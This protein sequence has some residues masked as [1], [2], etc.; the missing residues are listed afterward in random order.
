MKKKRIIISAVVCI[1]FALFAYFAGK[2]PFNVYP[3]EEAQFP[4]FTTTTRDKLLTAEHFQRM[5][6]LFVILLAA[7]AGIALIVLIRS[8]ISKDKRGHIGAAK[9]HKAFSRFMLIRW[10]SMIVLSFMMI[11]GGI[12][13]NARYE[14]IAIPVFACP[15]NFSEL[16][17]A[18]CFYLSHFPELLAHGIPATIIFLVSTLAFAIIFGRTICGF[19]CPMGLAQDILYKARQALK[20][21]GLAMNDRKYKYFVP[22]KWLMIILFFALVYAGGDFCEF[23]PAVVLSPVAAGIAWSLYFS[24]FFMIIVLIASFFKRR[25]FCNICP[26]GYLIGLLHKI[27]P[28]KIKK[29]CTACTEC[30]ACYEACPMGIKQIYTEREK[31]VVSDANCIMCGE[32]IRCCPEDNALY[33]TFV[34]KKLYTAKRSRVTKAYRNKKGGK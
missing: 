13:L 11:F 21:N 32:C 34:G 26:L 27:Q 4:P 5:R 23:C 12:L 6:P 10:I 24:G 31:T 25:A 20:V 14:S 33:M 18:S 2:F 8:L 17:E 22:V 19:F 3:P 9:S 30:G 16:T 7:F 15:V 28:F 1:V 29:D